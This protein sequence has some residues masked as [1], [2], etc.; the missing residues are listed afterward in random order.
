MSDNIIGVVGCVLAAYVLGSIPTA[1]WTGKWFFDKDIRKHGSGNAGATNAYRVLGPVAGIGVLLVD[2]LKGVA[3][4]SLAFLVRDYF[5]QPDYFVV[6]QF[7]LGLV[8]VTG[9]VFPVFA[10]FRGGKG[11]ATIAGVL[12]VIFPQVVLLCLGLFLLVF[13]F[14]RMV[15]LGSIAAALAFPV[16]VIWIQ[17]SALLT[18]KIFAVLIS[19]LVVLTHLKNIRRL[20]RG[21]E[22]RIRFRK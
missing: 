16:I 18:E 7:I 8:A 11:V 15:S 9:H 12:I 14:S 4:V 22:S 17:A 1:V 10:G 5:S 2:A 6:F 20:I 3:A 13:L 19:L 21:E